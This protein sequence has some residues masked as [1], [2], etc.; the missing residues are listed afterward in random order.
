MWW[1]ALLW[2]GEFPSCWTLGGHGVEQRLAWFP[3]LDPKLPPD[4][5]SAKQAVGFMANSCS[6]KQAFLATPT[7][8]FHLQ[9]FPLPNTSLSSQEGRKPSHFTRLHLNAF[10]TNVKLTSYRI[11]RSERLISAKTHHVEISLSI[12][13]KNKPLQYFQTST[14]QVPLLCSYRYNTSLALPRSGWHWSAG[15]RHYYRIQ[16]WSVVL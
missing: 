6:S 5:M 14:P 4:M 8:V 13:P 2:S 9:I 12:P 15:L 16:Y 7:V 1:L 10:L 11:L 3:K